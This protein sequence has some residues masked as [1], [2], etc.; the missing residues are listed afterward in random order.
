MSFQFMG[1]FR[2]REGDKD[3]LSKYL[4]ENRII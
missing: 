1:A 2:Q 3:G 4:I